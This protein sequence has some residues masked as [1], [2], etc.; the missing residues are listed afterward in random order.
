MG[1]LFSGVMQG[2]IHSNM[3]GA[4]G[5]AGWRWLFIIDGCIAVGI[6]IYGFIFFPD[7]PKKTRAFYFNKEVRRLI[8]S[9]P[10]LD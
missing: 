2:A 3:D 9:I 4:H 5:I 1:S 7:T 6:A 8:G 10:D